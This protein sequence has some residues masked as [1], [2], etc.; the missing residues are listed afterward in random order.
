MQ[1]SCTNGNRRLPT[2]FVNV[3]ASICAKIN[4]EMGEIRKRDNGTLYPSI[5]R[6]HAPIL[7]LT[8]GQREASFRQATATSKLSYG[9]HIS[10]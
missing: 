2:I 8:V 9:V 5:H 4:K 6:G 10:W 3:N 7:L 1:M